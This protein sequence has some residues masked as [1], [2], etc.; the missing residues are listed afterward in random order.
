MLHVSSRPLWQVHRL[1][2]NRHLWGTHRRIITG[3]WSALIRLRSPRDLTV[4][5][6]VELTV[7]TW[8]RWTHVIDFCLAVGIRWKYSVRAKNFS[9]LRLWGLA[10]R[11]FGLQSVV[12]HLL[13]WFPFITGHLRSLLFWRVQFCTLAR[14]WERHCSWNLALVHDPVNC[15]RWR[16]FTS[17]R[18]FAGHIRWRVEL[19]AILLPLGMLNHLLHIVE[20][21]ELCWVLHRQRSLF[22][23]VEHLRD[24]TAVDESFELSRRNVLHAEVFYHNWKSVQSENLV[25]RQVIGNWVFK[26]A[27]NVRDSPEVNDVYICLRYCVLE[28]DRLEE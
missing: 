22:N 13:F 23:Y 16:F 6:D 15:R 27:L 28:R 20:L 4:N 3:C 21:L 9:L 19:R 7:R 2:S 24:E 25:D 12:E 17:E 18:W 5:S 8:S 10:N 14:R 11:K 26:G 1:I